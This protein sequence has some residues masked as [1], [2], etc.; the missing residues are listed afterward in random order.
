MAD[1]ASSAVKGTRGRIVDLIRRSPCTATEIARELGLTYN[2]VRGHLTT[3]ER[4]GLV[5]S[6]GA[7][8][9]GA[10]R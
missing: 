10:L 7:R 1:Q 5:R 9:G 4:D 8:Q 6:R 2:A 3:L